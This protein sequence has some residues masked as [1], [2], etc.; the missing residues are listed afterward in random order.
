METEM[1]QNLY[2]L[3]SIPAYLSQLSCISQQSK[4]RLRNWTAVLEP[5]IQ[6][7]II[8]CCTCAI[9]KRCHTCQIDPQH[10]QSTICQQCTSTSGCIIGHQSDACKADPVQQSFYGPCHKSPRS[11]EVGYG[12]FRSSSGGGDDGSSGGGLATVLSGSSG[13][14]TSQCNVL[15]QKSQ[16]RSSLAGPLL[17]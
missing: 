13:E 9:Q 8:D 7:E 14:V 5:C 1:G 12:L 2:F 10:P 3:L 17:S 16:G 4:L 11:I 15:R 6:G